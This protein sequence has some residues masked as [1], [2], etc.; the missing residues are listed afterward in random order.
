M[1]LGVPVALQARTPQ[2]LDGVPDAEVPMLRDLDTL[3][4]GRIRVVMRWMLDGVVCGADM[5]HESLMQPRT[6]NTFEGNKPV[7]IAVLYFV[8]IWVG[9]MKLI[10]K[11]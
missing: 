9:L 5:L 1:L 4:S 11:P 3:D 10:P 2:I 8:N 6:S 7:N